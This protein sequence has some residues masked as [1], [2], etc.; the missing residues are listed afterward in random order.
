[1]KK[2]ISAA[3]LAII[4]LTTI[5]LQAGVIPGV[6][7]KVETIPE[8]YPV[9]VKLQGGE[10]LRGNF[11]FCSLD[12]ITVRD[13]TDAE[14]TIPRSQ[15]VKITSKKRTENDSLAQGA[16]IGAVA[17]GLV[18]IPLA[19]IASSE[20]GAGAAAVTVLFCTGIGA[21]IGV[22]TDAVV[23]GPEVFYQAPKD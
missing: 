10:K 5:A 8:G 13:E 14:R 11:L 12:G 19:M 17:G 15:V 9:V 6:W 23:K 18:S 7:A 21:G 4:S 3:V 2:K 16:I 1:M 22:A 20:D